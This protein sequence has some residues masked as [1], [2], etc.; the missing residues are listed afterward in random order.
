M[1]EFSR[2]ISSFDGVDTLWDGLWV[3]ATFWLLLIGLEDAIGGGLFG[4]LVA[5]AGRVVLA[6]LVRVRSETNSCSSKLL[7]SK[8]GL[9]CDKTQVVVIS[10]VG[11]QQ[12][13]GAISK[14]NYVLFRLCS[15]HVLGLL[16][17]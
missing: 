4:K 1:S 11:Y 13:E 7:S 2:K 6:D 14:L 3:F 8:A 17:L 5:V 10:K 12:Y 16:H 9:S 15:P